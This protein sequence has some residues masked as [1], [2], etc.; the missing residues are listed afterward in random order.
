MVPVDELQLVDTPYAVGV[1][2]RAGP[3]GGDVRPAAQPLPVS[4]DMESAKKGFSQTIRDFSPLDTVQVPLG[5]CCVLL[6]LA[7]ISER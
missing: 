2:L 6:V 1:V 5:G 4:T 3:G 7:V